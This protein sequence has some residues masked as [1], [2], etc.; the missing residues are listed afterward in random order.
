M[1]SAA[2]DL[3]RVAAG[4]GR[5]RPRPGVGDC[6]EG[7]ALVPHVALDRL[8]EVRDE[9]VAP[10]ELDVDLRPGLLRPVPERDQPVVG[11]DEPDQYEDDDANDDPGAHQEV[12][13]RPGA[14]GLRVGAPCPTG[15]LQHFLVLVLAHLLAPLLDYRA[16][17]NS[18]TRVILKRGVPTS[19]GLGNHTG[20]RQ[21]PVLS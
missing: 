6:F 17:S 13:L 20:R 5:N 8:D 2:L 12:I 4:A 10:L 9:V 18:Q 14:F 16:Q 11:E 3:G 21:A 7:A 19:S 15:L 1:F